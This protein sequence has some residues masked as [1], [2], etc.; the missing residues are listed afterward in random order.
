M[1]RKKKSGSKKLALTALV[2]VL[3]VVLVALL[4]ATFYVDWVLDKFYYD[5]D[6]NEQTLSSQQ[7]EELL[8]QPDETIDPTAVTVDPDELVWGDAKPIESANH[9]YNILLVGQDRR[10]G[11]I[12]ARSDSM[13]LVT[14][15][16]ETKQV[17]LTS[18]MRDMYVQIPGFGSN[19]MNVPYAIKGAELL[20]DTMEKNFGLRPDKFVEV[21]FNGF[22]KAVELVGGVDIYLTAAEAR[23]LN[24]TEEGYDYPEEDWHLTEGINHLDGKQALAFARCRSV[25]GT[26][27]FSR[28]RRQRDVL[29]AL[30]EKAAT[31]NP[32]ELNQLVLAMSEYITTD[33]TSEEIIGY[34]VTFA[35]LLAEL[36]IVN[37]RIPADN[38]FYMAN[39]D[40]VGS[41]LV[42]DLEKN[43]AILAATQN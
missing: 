9:I 12:R 15:N 33:M 14:V 17:T 5:A 3:S 35:P 37:M 38:S 24:T 28:T 27:D 42:P 2:C 39:I 40:G 36:Q 31:L 22:T 30:L 43:R 41:V 11:E 7:L 10:P 26:G 34:A 4:G 18:I 13:I 29:R 16:T 19:R 20:F 25:D 1:K 6:E 32:L 21:D 23:H 8:T